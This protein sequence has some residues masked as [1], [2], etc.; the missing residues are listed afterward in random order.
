MNSPFP[1][2]EREQEQPEAV[3]NPWKGPADPHWYSGMGFTED[4]AYAGPVYRALEAAGSGAAKGEAVLGGLVNAAGRLYSSVGTPRVVGQELEPIGS[5][6]QADA[7]ERVRAMTP[8]ATT[9][10]SAV[11][12]LHGVVEGGYLLTAGNLAGGPVGGALT[13]GGI[14]GGSRYQELREEGVDTGTAARSGALTG[15][16][17]G[18]GAL[19]PA[20]YGATLLTRVLTGAGSNTAFGIADRYLDHKI[21]ERGGYPEMA[22]QQKALDATQVLIDAALGATFGGIH[23][24]TANRTVDQQDAA[25][26]ANLALHDR[27]SAPGV[28][29]NPEAANAHQAALEKA[30]TDIL[31]GKPVDVSDSGV[32]RARFLSRTTRDL[33]PENEIILKS[34]KESGLLDEEANLRDLEEQF[35]QRRNGKAESVKPAA[36]EISG[37][38]S[39]R[40]EPLT[41]EQL[42]SFK[43]LR[44]EVPADQELAPAGERESGQSGP[45]NAGGPGGNAGEPLRVFRGASHDLASEHF[46]LEA[47]GHATGHPSSGLGVFF[48]LSKDEAAHYGEVTEHHL[49]IRNPKIIKA[50]DLPSFDSV[51]EAHA[52]REKLR[53]QGYDGIV[54]DGSHLGGPVNYVAFEP[55]QVIPTEHTEPRQ[56]S[57]DPVEQ[58]LAQRP[59]LTIANEN[60]E[61][62]R[63]ADELKAAT[64][65][66][67]W[68]KATK[69]ATHCF[70]RRGG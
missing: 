64:S 23:H 67:D 47:L 21:L 9:T 3:W 37:E 41:D 68:F 4:T 1:L 55:H 54:I 12:V 25:L 31:A 69:A 22:E 24:L 48:S 43:G 49:D 36:E 56:V 53:A 5:N 60:G 30:Q 32:D 46:D 42:Q 13:V 17:S 45:E 44:S 58:A 19:L 52:Y 11:K 27:Q 6:V 7:R 66:D 35:A 34:F 33:T 2:E 50:E 28:A 18:A 63:A 65:E 8:D 62:V 14:E 39:V 59:D 15:V 20:A 38:Y 16:T 61:P 51:E 10:G 57:G 29:V 70:S 40:E 26:T